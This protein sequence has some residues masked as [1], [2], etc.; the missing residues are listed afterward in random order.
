MGSEEVGKLGSEEAGRMERTEGV[1]V[2]GWESE[3]PKQEKLKA[4]S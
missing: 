3:G 4:Q 1:R 2:R